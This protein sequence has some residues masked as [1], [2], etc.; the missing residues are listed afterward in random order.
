MEESCTHKRTQG[1]CCSRF[2]LFFSI[3]RSACGL[4]ASDDHWTL[5]P[6]SKDLRSREQGNIKQVHA[7]IC[8]HRT[9]ER[10]NDP[11]ILIEYMWRGVFF[12]VRLNI[13]AFSSK[14]QRTCVEVFGYRLNHCARAKPTS[15]DVKW[16]EVLVRSAA[17]GIENR[18]VVKHSPKK[19]FQDVNLIR[20]CNTG[21]ER[22]QFIHIKSSL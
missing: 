17:G 16:L 9:R 21:E 1:R 6:A 4:Y 7:N 20:W 14:H 2:S 3:A 15:A 18:T 11:Q 10:G 19:Y 8:T 22:D 5:Q 13:S 12:V